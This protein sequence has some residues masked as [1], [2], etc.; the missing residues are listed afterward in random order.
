MKTKDT[1]IARND[2]KKDAKKAKKEAKHTNE[3]P[4]QN[5]PKYNSDITADDKHILKQKNIHTDGGDDRQLKER[6]RS[7]DFAGL[8]LDVPGRTDAK[9][10]RGPT[11]LNDEE[12]KVHS[13]GGDTKSNLERDDAAK[14]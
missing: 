5:N 14:K 9:K 1:E 4:D 7:V 8:D 2:L 12:N 13:Q 10:G 3:K 6:E 11:G